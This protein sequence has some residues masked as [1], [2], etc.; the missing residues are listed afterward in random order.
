MERIVWDDNVLPSPQTLIAGLDES[1]QALFRQLCGLDGGSRLLRFLHA[2]SNSVLTVDDI[3]YHLKQ[4]PSTVECNLHKLVELG[5]AR[6]LD[7]PGLTWFGLT[8]DPQKRKIVRELFAW[9]E[10]WNARLE[11]IRLAIEGQMLPA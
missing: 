10:H 1:V 7:L 5:W 11:R 3:A 2:N 6:R 8:A 4:T 9:Q